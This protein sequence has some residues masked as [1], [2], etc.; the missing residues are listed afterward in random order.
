ML[1]IREF[2]QRR[3]KLKYP[4]RRKIHSQKCTYLFMKASCVVLRGVRLREVPLT[5]Y[6]IRNSLKYG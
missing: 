5:Q 6:I 4:A 2:E 3:P 1:A